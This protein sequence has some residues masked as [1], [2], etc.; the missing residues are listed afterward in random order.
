[1]PTLECWT[2]SHGHKRTC[3]GSVEAE[4]GKVVTQIRELLR[5]PIDPYTYAQVD[6]KGIDPNVASIDEQGY[7]G[8]NDIGSHGNP[9]GWP[10]MVEVLKETRQHLLKGWNQ[11]QYSRNSLG[12]GESLLSEK[13][14]SFCLSGAVRLASINWLVSPSPVGQLLGQ[15]IGIKYKRNRCATICWNDEAGRT[16]QDMIDLLDFALTGKVKP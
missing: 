13:A 3:L 16:K 4:P 11:G 14:C 8:L 2:W 9:I 1:M 5:R 12:T 7:L 6:L 10:D 15:A